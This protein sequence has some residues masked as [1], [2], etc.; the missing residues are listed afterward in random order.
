MGNYIAV[1]CSHVTFEIL[2]RYLNKDIK[3]AVG[4]INLRF[5]ATGLKM[6]MSGLLLHRWSVKLWNWMRVPPRRIHR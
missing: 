5:V 6:E 1:H 2:A 3:I 4:Y